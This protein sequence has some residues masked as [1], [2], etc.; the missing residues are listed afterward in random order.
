MG[1]DLYRENYRNFPELLNFLKD[2][3]VKAIG[4]SRLV[5]IGKG[6]TLEILG[7]KELHAFYSFVMNKKRELEKEGIHL[8][9]HCS[10]A[11]WFIE[12]PVYE[13]HGCSAG[14]DS[15]SILSNGDV[16]PCRRLPVKVGN[17]LDR[18]LIDIWY[19]SDFLWKLRNKGNIAACKNCE[20]FARCFG[21]ARC[22]AYGY[23]NNSFAPD[24]QCWKLFDSLP[25]RTMPSAVSDNL[26]TFNKAY[27]ENFNPPKKYFYEKPHA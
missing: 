18:S 19:T 5:P 11:V 16:V 17:V 20:L 6:K 3:G 10:D 12:D 26:I 14:Y 8:S 13:T 7:P 21:G 2:L 1:F 25:R 23:F 22:V 9:T 27:I 4:V 15:F 24:P